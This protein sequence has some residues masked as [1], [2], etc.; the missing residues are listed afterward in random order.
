MTFS[1]MWKIP[2][3]LRLMFPICIAFY[4]SHLLRS[5]LHG[6]QPLPLLCDPSF[7]PCNRCH[8][9][10]INSNLTS[11]IRWSAFR[12]S[13]IVALASSLA[14]RNAAIKVLCSSRS[15]PSTSPF[16]SHT[17]TLA[18]SDTTFPSYLVETRTAQR[19]AGSTSGFED[20]GLQVYFPYFPYP[21]RHIVC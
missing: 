4:Q 16:V 21:L 6:A 20:L 11:G 15:S 2:V 18:S 9:Y 1:P 13:R 19:W 10:R 7:L 12:I 14:S 17:S 5:S 3:Y 8:M